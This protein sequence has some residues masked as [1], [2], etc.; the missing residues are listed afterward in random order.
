M[1]CSGTLR[2]VA[3]EI[4]NLLQLLVT[5]SPI[6][7]TL[8]MEAIRSS[9]TSVLTR[10]IWCNISVGGILQEFLQLVNT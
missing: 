4:T 7:V 8:R 9:E 2:R 3:V 1:P 6:V 10:A 5:S